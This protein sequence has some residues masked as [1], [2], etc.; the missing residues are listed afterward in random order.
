MGMPLI[1]SFPGS[2]NSEIPV[3]QA[4]LEWYIDLREVGAV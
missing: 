3:E 4:F 1:I 2:M